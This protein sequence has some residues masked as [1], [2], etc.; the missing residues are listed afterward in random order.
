MGAPSGQPGS[1]SYGDENVSPGAPANEE[2]TPYP[3]LLG[4]APLVRGAIALRVC[5]VQYLRDG[6]RDR[7]SS[8]AAGVPPP[9]NNVTTTNS[10]GITKAGASLWILGNATQN[11]TANSNTYTGLTTIGAGQLRATDG[12][13]LPTLSPVFLTG[14]VLETSGTFGRTVLS[15]APTATSANGGVFWSTGGGFARVH[16]S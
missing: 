3:T 1:A 14:G 4:I 8:S 13:T 15:T 16:R 11:A 6:R 12:N 2:A 10:L 5:S 7:R 9:A